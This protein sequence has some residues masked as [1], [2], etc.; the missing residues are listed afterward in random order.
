MT[1]ISL[2]VAAAVF[3]LTLATALSV[4]MFARGDHIDRVASSLMVGTVVACLI[5]CA[6]TMSSAGGGARI[7]G[8]PTFGLL[9][10]ICVGIGGIWVLASVWRSRRRK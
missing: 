10:F 4:S 8:L 1:M 2:P 9:R 5:I 6:S 3:V 7:S